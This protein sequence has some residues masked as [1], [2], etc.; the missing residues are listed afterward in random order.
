MVKGNLP[1]RHYSGERGAG[2]KHGYRRWYSA[3]VLREGVVP[4]PD[5]AGT[6]T[7]LPENRSSV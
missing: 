3:Y 7:D 5:A 4:R 2:N 6:R 1:I